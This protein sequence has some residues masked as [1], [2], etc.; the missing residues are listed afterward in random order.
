VINVFGFRSG[1]SIYCANL[2][3]DES[4]D[5]TALNLTRE[6]GALEKKEEKEKS[7]SLKCR[8]LKKLRVKS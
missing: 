8:S 5:C 3:L 1:Y 7:C 6:G 2:K 4:N